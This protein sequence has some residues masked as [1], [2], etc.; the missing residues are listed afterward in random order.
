MPGELVSCLCVT[1]D[2][3]PL[4]RRAVACFVAQT[5]PARE[6]VVLFESDDSATRDYL[7]SVSDPRIRALEVP[8]R[9]KRSLGALRNLS[10]QAAAGR[11]LAQWDDDDWY[12]PA[13]LA[14][15]LA[16]LQAG[17]RPACVLARWILFDAVT[18]AAYLSA[19]RNWEGSLLAE[20]VALPAYADLSRREDAPVLEQMA[21]EGK[22]VVL[23]QPWLIVYTHHGNNTWERSHWRGLVQRAQPLTNDQAAQVRQLLATPPTAKNPCPGSPAP[24]A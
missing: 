3:V 22:L 1:R 10:V 14:S 21:V 23:D 17:Q 13:R 7:A 19:R 18:G 8:A 16:A 5:H 11:Y 9:P 20:V 24:V 4:L 12:A 6:L 2:R 15:Q